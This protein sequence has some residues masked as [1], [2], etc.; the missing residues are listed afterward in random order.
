MLALP[1][2]VIHKSGDELKPKLLTSQGIRVK[3]E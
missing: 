3:S 2:L 1:A